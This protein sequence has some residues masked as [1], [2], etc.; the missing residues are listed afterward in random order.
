MLVNISWFL[1]AFVIHGAPA[2][3]L[4]RPHMISTLY[5]VSAD[6][7]LGLLLIHRAA[8]FLAIVAIALYAL[9][10]HSARRPATIV[11]SISMI[12]FLVLYW[13]AGMPDG[14]LRNIAIADLIGLAPLSVVLWD[15]WRS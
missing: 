13:Q 6:G 2:I 4:F 10:D 11:L 7:D 3:L 9:I 15:A 1:L 12:S 5:G 14:P 8:L